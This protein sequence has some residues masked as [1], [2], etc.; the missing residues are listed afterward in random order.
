M[1][2]NTLHPIYTAKVLLDQIINRNHL[3]AMV[4][5]S[6]GLGSR[7]IPG[8]IDYSCGKSFASFLAEGLNYELK[9][10]VDCMSWQSGKVKTKINGHSDEHSVSVE[11]AVAGMLRDLGHESMTYG[12]T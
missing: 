6:S 2:I 9:G 8:C 3:A 7:P 1:A 10:R 5:T 11:T 4:V 12:C